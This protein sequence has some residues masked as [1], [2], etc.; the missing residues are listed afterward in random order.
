[1]K[2]I[3]SLKIILYLEVLKTKKIDILQQLMILMKLKIY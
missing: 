1:M 3:F 2:D